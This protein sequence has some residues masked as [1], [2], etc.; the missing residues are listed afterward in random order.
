MYRDLF[1]IPLL[2]Y[3]HSIPMREGIPADQVADGAV[4]PPSFAPTLIDGAI[5]TA[6]V[7]VAF[8]CSLLLWSVLLFA[9]K[10]PIQWFHVP[11]A[12]LLAGGFGLWAA[13]T[14]FPRE[15]GAPSCSR[16]V[17]AA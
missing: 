17:P 15:R 2:F 6:A 8:V 13:G 3:L 12:A 5:L 10:T 1:A 9:L 16:T 7:Q 11:A 4:L 14:L